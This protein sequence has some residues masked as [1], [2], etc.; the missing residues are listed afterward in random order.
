MCIFGLGSLTIFGH[1][2]VILIAEYEIKLITIP[3]TFSALV[4]ALATSRPFLI[5][6]IL[7]V[8][9]EEAENISK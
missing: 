5:A 6:L 7:S 9:A 1:D 2:P 8:S 3:K 4:D